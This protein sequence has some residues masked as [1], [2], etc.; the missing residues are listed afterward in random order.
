MVQILPHEAES[1][2]KLE[3]LRRMAMTLATI[4]EQVLGPDL[5]IGFRAYDGSSLGPPDP[6]ATIVVRNP[7]A[8]RR[9]VTSPGELGLARAYVAGDLD[10]EGDV[11][12]LLELRDRLPQV[13]IRHQ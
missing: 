9:I 6:R 5:P 4:V 8:I 7:D 12:A 10:L 11:F 2:P 3:Q 1:H 13:R